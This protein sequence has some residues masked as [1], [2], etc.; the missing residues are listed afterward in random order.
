MAK[1]CAYCGGAGPFTADH[2]WLNCFLDRF[3]RHAALCSVRGQQVHGADYV[4]K[5]VCETCNSEKLSPLDSY[6]CRLYD[7]YL[8]HLHDFNSTVALHYD[9]NLLSRSLLKIAHNSARQGVSDAGPLAVLRRFIAGH[10]FTLCSCPSSPSLYR[11]Q[12]FRSPMEAFVRSCRT[13]ID[14]SL[15]SFSALAV[16]AHYAQC[17]ITSISLCL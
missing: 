7:E 17:G 5:D 1:E 6:F 12:W 4:V 3:G 14:P 13:C 8:V 15:V 16:I 2:V 11:R 10:D 9:F